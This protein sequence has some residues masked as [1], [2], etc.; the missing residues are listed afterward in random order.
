MMHSNDLKIREMFNMR[1]ESRVDSDIVRLSSVTRCSDRKCCLVP[2]TSAKFL[3]VA[4]SWINANTACQNAHTQS[5]LTAIFPGQCDCVTY[6]WTDMYNSL[7]SGAIICPWGTRI[8][9]VTRILPYQITLTLWARME[10]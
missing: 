8:P 10:N 7:Q 3:S 1:S 4:V 6:P 9:T 2:L 5:V